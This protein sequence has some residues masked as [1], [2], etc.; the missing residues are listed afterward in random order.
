M[1]PTAARLVPNSMT[2]WTGALL[3]RSC[4][5]VRTRDFYGSPPLQM[6]HFLLFFK[7]CKARGGTCKPEE[8]EFLN[9]CAA[10]A[11]LFPCEEGCAIE[12]GPELP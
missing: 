12:T 7:A 4:D 1:I 2:I 6:T 3:N 10:M 11:F 5:D 8:L 9:S